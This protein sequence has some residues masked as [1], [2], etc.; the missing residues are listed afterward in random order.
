MFLVPAFLQ[1]A[2]G[3]SALTAGLAMVPQAILMGLGML[4]GTKLPARVGLT[5][6]VVGGVGVLGAST[7]ALLLL[8]AL[9]PVWVYAAVLAGRG[10]AV[11]LVVQPVLSALLAPVPR[12]QLPDAT[13]A[14]TV[15]E[16]VAGTFG[17]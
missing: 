8:G 11:G 12:E 2:G 15:V 17:V 16:Q 13:T 5:P 14:F 10:L 4:A 1:T 9:S 3:H 7:A 6:T